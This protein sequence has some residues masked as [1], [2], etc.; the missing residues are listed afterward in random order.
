MKGFSGKGDE[1]EKDPVKS[2]WKKLA[3]ETV[4]F[5]QSAQGEKIEVITAQS[6]YL[7]KLCER[8]QSVRTDGTVICSRLNEAI[9]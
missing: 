2:C 9:S 6:S 4:S 7:N 3:P 8:R 5:E 1:S